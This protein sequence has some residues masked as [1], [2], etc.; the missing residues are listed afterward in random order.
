M[1][2]SLVSILGLR[3]F[4][5]QVLYRHS[6]M[7]LLSIH[8]S[9]FCLLVKVSIIRL[10]CVLKLLR[11]LLGDISSVIFT[12][13]SLLRLALLSLSQRELNSICDSIIIGIRIYGLLSLLNLGFLNLSLFNL[14]LFSDSFFSYSLSLGFLSL[15]RLVKSYVKI[16]TSVLFTKLAFKLRGIICIILLISISL[17]NYCYVADDLVIRLCVSSLFLGI[18]GLVSLLGNN[19]RK[20]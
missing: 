13:L 11:F 18:L 4:I 5:L 14:S 8:F 9:L 19:G 1:L 6:D 20:L 2:I 17:G 7:G 15:S 16:V 3:H 12:L 10:Y